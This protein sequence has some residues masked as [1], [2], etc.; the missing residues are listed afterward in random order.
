MIFSRFESIGTYLP[1]RVVTT[2][3]LI[4][5]LAT[6]PSFDFTA[7]TGVQERR[8]RGEDEDSFSMACL[9]AEECLNKS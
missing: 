7:I 9:A 2:E 8:F 5:Q 4:G 6:P 3:E 1:S